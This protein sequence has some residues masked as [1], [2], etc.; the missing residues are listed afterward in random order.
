MSGVNRMTDN[1]YTKNKDCLAEVT[2]KLGVET[3]FRFTLDIPYLDENS[4]SLA[5]NEEDN[6]IGSGMRLLVAEDNELNY[7][8][9]SEQL[10]MHSITC[11][12]AENGK[13]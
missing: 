12:R 5:A 6:N 9:L 13:K 2:S 7:E 4:I 1:G 8:I 10:K 11:D 3:A